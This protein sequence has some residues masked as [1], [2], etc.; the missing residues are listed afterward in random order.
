MNKEELPLLDSL[1]ALTVIAQELVRNTLQI[2]LQGAMSIEDE[3]LTCSLRDGQRRSS[4][5]LANAA[6]QSVETLLRMTELRGIP[7][8]DAYPIA[9]S[10]VETF[11]NASYLIAEDDQVAA[12]AIRYVA[13]ADWR[14]LNTRFGSGEFSM[15]ISSDSNPSDTISQAFPEF[16][17]RGNGSWTQLDV[18]SRIRRIGEMASPRA[19][20]LLLA[21]YGLIYSISSE[22]IH[23]SNFGVSYFYSA[24]SGRERSTE[25]FVAG[26]VKQLEDIIFASLHSICGYLYTYFEIQ[27]MQKPLTTVEKIYKRVVVLASK[28]PDDFPSTSRLQKGTQSK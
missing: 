22:V 4:M 5:V 28:A 20:T 6:S 27:G 7:V 16:S 9:R 25:A 1:A 13:F 15:E 12:R 14:L 2:S 26:T 24:H 10:V 8:R 21:A 11:V 23:G 3:E 19:G 18:P 17:G